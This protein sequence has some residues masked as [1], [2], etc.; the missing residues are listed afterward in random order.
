MF[1]AVFDFPEKNSFNLLLFIM[2]VSYT[3]CKY[4]SGGRCNN[5]EFLYLKA[6]VEYIKV[7]ILWEYVMVLLSINE[8][9]CVVDLLRKAKSRV[10]F[11]VRELF[12]T[13]H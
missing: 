8:L 6:P 1:K 9:Y 3:K 2:T 13:I 4:D 11:G 7:N 5:Q 12:R 10:V